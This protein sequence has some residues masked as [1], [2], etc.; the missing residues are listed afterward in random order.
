MK[1]NL[2]IFKMLDYIIATNSI[3]EN[4]G[5]DINRTRAQ[6]SGIRFTEWREPLFSHALSRLL[7]K[8]EVMCSSQVGEQTEITAQSVNG[9][10]KRFETKGI[11]GLYTRPG[12]AHNRLPDEDAVRRAIESYRQSVRAAK[13]A[14]QKASGKEASGLTFRRFYPYWRKI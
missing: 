9:W 13:E 10:V 8:S 11:K 1:N 3:N 4:Q 7:L 12:Q 14:W 6:V 2:R 5:I